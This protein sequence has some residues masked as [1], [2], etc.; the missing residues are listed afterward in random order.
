MTKRLL[1]SELGVT[2]ETLSR[3]L[4]KFRKHQLVRVEGR[5][6]T[7]TCPMRLATIVRS[8]LAPPPVSATAP[9]STRDNIFQMA[10]HGICPQRRL[11]ILPGPRE[12]HSLE[13]ES[14][15]GVKS[16]SFRPAT[17]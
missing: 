12:N 1:A 10:A 15:L 3:T 11:R 7:L 16:A 14:P 9:L 13:I 8:N 4:A 17:S 6:V 2:S 5:A